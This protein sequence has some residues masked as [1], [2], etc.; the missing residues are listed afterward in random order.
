MKQTLKK[1]NL[2]LLIALFGSMMFLA[3]NC[4]KDD[5]PSDS[6][7][8]TWKLSLK[9]D[10]YDGGG[11]RYCQYNFK[12]D[13]TFEVKYWTSESKEPTSYEETGKWWTQID[14][15]YLIFTNFDDLLVTYSYKLDGKKLI[16]YGMGGSGPNVFE[17]V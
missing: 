2:L 13:G 3:T 8:G 15:L 16:I 17:K 1:L 11:Y 10:S 14:I 12:K 6:I 7:V 5:E 4:D 9:D